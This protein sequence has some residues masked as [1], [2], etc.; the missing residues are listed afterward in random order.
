MVFDFID[1]A[2]MF[3][4]ALSLHRLF[5]IDKYR[6]N[7]YVLAPDNLKEFENNMLNNGEKPAVYLDFPVNVTDYEYIDLFNWQEEVKN[8]IS[9]IEFVRMVDVQEETISRYIR[10]GKIIP[11]LKVPA[12]SKYFNYFKKET[13]LKYAGEYGWRLIN[14]SNMKDIFIEMVEKMDMSYS[15]KPVLLKAMLECCDENGKALI[16]DVV[17]YFIKFYE[18]RKNKNLY[19]EKPNSI[20]CRDEIDKKS[21]KRNIFD[22]PFKR[23]ED[24]RFLRKSKDIEYIEFNPYVW[25]KLSQEEKDWIK[26]LCDEKLEDYYSRFKN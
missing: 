5:N 22:N 21:V 7:E 11:D 24:M 26:T 9:Q 25:K 14:H 18:D 13:A 19:V 6:P 17:E 12:G 1:N 2:N 8:L 15:Y 3:N 16:D 23:F 4:N 20:Y 10:E